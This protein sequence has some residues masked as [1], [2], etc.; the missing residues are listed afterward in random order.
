L[1][2]AIPVGSMVAVDCLVQPRTNARPKYFSDCW[3]LWGNVT[4]DEITN[5]QQV[6]VNLDDFLIGQAC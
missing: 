4:T 3:F 2:G 5:L 6:V 1:A